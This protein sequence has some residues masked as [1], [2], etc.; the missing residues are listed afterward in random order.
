MYEGEGEDRPV[1]WYETVVPVSG[2][3]ECQ[4]MQDGMLEDIRCSIGHQ[5]IEVR[6]DS[7]GEERKIALEL[8]LDLDLK[9][10]EDTQLD[11]ISDLYGVHQEIEAV[12]QLGCCKQL[13]AKTVGKAKV[14]GRFK[15]APGLPKMQQLSGSFGEIWM[16]SAETCPEGLKLTGN[17]AVRTVYTTNDGDLPIYCLKGSIP[18]SYVLEAAG[19]E[20]GCQYEISPMLEELSVNLVDGDEA[21]SHAMLSFKGLISRIHEEQMLTDMKISELDPE[22]LTSLPGIVAYIVRDGD[23]LWNIGKKYYVTT[24]RLREMNDIGSED[25]KRGDRLL[26]VKGY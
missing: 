25:V 10:Y 19:T 1:I 16:G 9:L 23:S 20:N 17:V 3:V 2:T 13:L 22:K 8:A 15:V 24:A 12:R 21:E 7:D 14:S 5:E 11:M 4:G 26:V 18:F 6:Q